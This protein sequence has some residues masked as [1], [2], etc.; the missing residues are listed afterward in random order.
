MTTLRIATRKSPLALW[1]SEHVADRLRQAHPGLEVT[2]VPMSTRGDEV[3]DRSLAAIGGKGLFLKELEL[4]MLRGEADCAVHSLKDVPMELEAPFVLPAILTRADPADAFVSNHYATLD[5]LPHGAV[6]GTSSLRRQAQL[7]ALRPDLQSRDLR[8]NVNTRL[9]KLDAGD[10]DAIILACAGLERLQ[11]GGRIRSRLVEPQWL[12]APAQA[13]VAIECRA[14]ATEVIARVATLDDAATRTC[15]E[16]E[17]AMNRALE[18]SCHVPVA[19]LAQWQGQDLWLQG[20][21][22]GVADGRIVRTEAL[23]PAADPEALGRRVAAQLLQ[24]GAADLLR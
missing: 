11:L 23:G 19:G 2:L 5:Q 10:Y 9:A 3:L 4:A 13:A 18:G 21:V 24:A 6:V 20:L 17:R 16:A 12:P 15:V 8:G 7:R 14:D 1:Q 22:G